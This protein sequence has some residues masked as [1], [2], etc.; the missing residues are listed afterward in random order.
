ML[1]G[2][3]ESVAGGLHKVFERARVDACRAV[4]IFTKNANQWREPPLAK[5]DV[6][7]F[8]AAHADAGMIPVLSHTSYLI[9]LAAD[10]PELLERSKD[11]LARE[12]LR[13]S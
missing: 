3:H 9:N 10:D 12:L 13:S 11:A 7:A 4:Q 8:R 6:R 5:E 1:L 2:A